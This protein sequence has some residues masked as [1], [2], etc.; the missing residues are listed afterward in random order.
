MLSKK[1]IRIVQI[2]FGIIAVVSS[3]I[4]LVFPDIGIYAILFVIALSFML[5]GVERLI[6]GVFLP[7]IKQVKNLN[8]GLGIASI[9]ISVI[10]ILFPNIAIEILV[11]LI[12]F[13]LMFVGI[14]RII[15]AVKNKGLKNWT[16][17]IGIVVGLIGIGLAVGSMIYESFGIILINFFISIGLLAL[18][19]ELIIAGITGGHY[20]NK[21]DLEDLR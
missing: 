20:I 8:I 3:A 1:S 4:I 10:C 14:S 6:I 9:V 21:K 5:M 12:S 2:I 17:I 11:V 7:L 13:V 16:R 18:G 19:L 15:N